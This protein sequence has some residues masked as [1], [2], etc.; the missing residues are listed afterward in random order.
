MSG[1]RVLKTRLKKFKYITENTYRN[2]GGEDSLELGVVHIEGVTHLGY[3]TLCGAV[4][5][6]QATMETDDPVTCGGCLETYNYARN[7][8]I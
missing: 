2:F 6:M 7:G 4:D 1:G 3:E 8:I 5:S